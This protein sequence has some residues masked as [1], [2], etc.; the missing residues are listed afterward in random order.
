MIKEQ[1]RE[2]LEYCERVRGMSM[3]TVATKRN[4][5]ERFV[6]VTGAERMEEVDDVK[7]HKWVSQ[8]KMSGASARSINVYNSVVVAMVKYCR[9]IGVAVPVNL[10][11]VVRMK[12]TVVARGYYTAEEV[13]RA[14][15]AALSLGDTQTALMISVMFETGMRISEAC[16]MRACEI[17]G[18]RVQFVGKGR[19]A[20][21]VYMTE[22][23]AAEVARFVREKGIHEGYVWR[24][25]EV[26]LMHDGLEPLTTQTVRGRM[27]R[28]FLAA[29]LS[30]FYPHAL[31]H[32]FATD[33]QRRGASVAEIKEMMG[34]ANIATTERYLHGLD[35]RMRELFDRYR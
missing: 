35:G 15:A 4:V 8:L 26:G 25:S 12:E 22:A 19:K 17:T 32:S 13:M 1:I 23:T 34:H 11:L 33:L 9:E 28:A 3:V 7:M 14:V 20:R 6:R 21:E 16:R 5:L 27:R 30:G 29:G 31:R 18:R 2:Y 24:M 10:A